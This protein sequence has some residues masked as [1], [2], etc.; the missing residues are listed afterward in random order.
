MSSEFGTKLKISIFGQSHSKAIGVCIDGLPAGEHIDMEQ[1]QS[2]MTRLAPGQALSTKRK[3]P[4]IPEILSGIVDSHTCGAPLCAMIENADTRSQDYSL[5]RDIPRPSHADYT[6]HVKY[7][8]FNDI[9][10]GGHFSGRLTAPLCFAGAVCLQILERKGIHIGGHIFSIGDIFDTPFDPVNISSEEFAVIFAK[11]FPVICDK[12]GDEMK[13]MVKAAADAGDSVGGVIE[14]A[15]IGVPAGIGDPIFDG[16]ESRLASIIFSIPAV[17]GVE[18][19][20]G[21]RSAKLCG[22]QN[23]D[24]FIYKDGHIVTETNNH[25]GILGG[26]SSGMPIVMR[27]AFKPTPSIAIKQRSVNLRTGE[28]TTLSIPGR[29]DPCIAVRA[30]PCV[31]SA[32]A[33]GIFDLIV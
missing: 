31:I 9:A 29:H 18:F 6:A 30:L 28:N 17:K 26:I 13:A 33:I 32:A 25:G 7:N 12:S 3:E 10:G 19:G 8:G 11:D 27:A 4:D 5:F 1:V 15:A 16:I 23:N 14:C 20:A 21:F 22:S 2:F 24:P